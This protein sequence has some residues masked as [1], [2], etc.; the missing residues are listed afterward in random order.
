MI[1]G[2]GWAAL[3]ESGWIIAVVVRL[4][5]VGL[6]VASFVVAIAMAVLGSAI[7]GLGSPAR[8]RGPGFFSLGP[9]A[10]GFRP[11]YVVRGPGSVSLFLLL[12]PW[13]LA[14]RV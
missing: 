11:G 5:W 8:I 9:R 13:F 6:G 10:S 2:F 14:P 12:C 7:R 4:G 3:V 1:R